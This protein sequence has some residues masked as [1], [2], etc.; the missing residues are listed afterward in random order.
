[1]EET[2]TNPAATAALGLG[3]LLWLLC[4]VGTCIGF[5]PVL[6]LLTTF[7]I[8]P[9]EILVSLGAVGAGIYGIVQSNA[10][11]EGKV[12]AIV[13]I[14]G[15]VLWYGLQ[16]MRILFIVGMFALAMLNQ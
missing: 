3:V 9:I 1:M 7:V 15:A 11:G 14:V 12:A 2:P 8:F 6:G 5:V 13:G 4:A 16:A 10:T